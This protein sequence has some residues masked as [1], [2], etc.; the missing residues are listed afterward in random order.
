MERKQAKQQSNMAFD[1]RK[2]ETNLNDVSGT[3]QLRKPSPHDGQSTTSMPAVRA[4]R[5]SGGGD[6]TE[7]E[8][9]R[10]RPRLQRQQRRSA[11]ASGDEGR[12]QSIKNGKNEEKDFSDQDEIDRDVTTVLDIEKLKRLPK[13]L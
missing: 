9:S 11:Q 3:D 2:Y 4:T 5:A 12:S 6:G 1:P 7:A 13:L 10:Q 8:G